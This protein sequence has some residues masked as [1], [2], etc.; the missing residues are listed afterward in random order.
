MTIRPFLDALDRLV[1]SVD[2][3]F[4]PDRLLDRDLTS[5]T[6]SAYHD[7]NDSMS[8]YRR[9][10]VIGVPNIAPRPPKGRGHRRPAG[11]TV[12]AR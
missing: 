1:T 11:P 10:A 4:L 9:P 3:E 12:I 8:S 5:F 2:G 6:Y 7:M